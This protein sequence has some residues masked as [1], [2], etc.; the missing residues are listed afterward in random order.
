[1]LW[2]T[3]AT[4]LILSL[5]GGGGTPW[6]A[7]LGDLASDVME[8]GPRLDRA[9]EASDAMMET[10]ADFEREVQIHRADLVALDADYHATAEDYRRVLGKL[11]QAWGERMTR[12]I[13]LRYDFRDQF[14]REE[15]EDLVRRLDAKLKDK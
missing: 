2:A 10:L 14:T 15:W 5:G 3:L 1:M 8:D 13:A 6:F 4:I 9:M 12:I 7:T 11:D